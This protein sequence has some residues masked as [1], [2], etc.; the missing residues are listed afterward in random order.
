MP[1]HYIVGRLV[2]IRFAYWFPHGI[3]VFFRSPGKKLWKIEPSLKIDYNSY[4]RASPMA[5]IVMHAS[6]AIVTKITVG[7]IALIAIL[8]NAPLWAIILLI[9]NFAIYIGTDVYSFFS[10]RIMADWR[11]VRRE[12]SYLKK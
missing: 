12:W 8:F 11:R 10:P 6:G 2:G 5:R 7:A 4:L 1:T 3:Y 9:A